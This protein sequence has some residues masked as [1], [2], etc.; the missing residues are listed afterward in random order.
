MNK[1]RVLQ[2]NFIDKTTYANIEDIN[3]SSVEVRL[4]SMTIF[5][6][7]NYYTDTRHSSINL[8]VDSCNPFK[9][10]EHRYLENSNWTCNC[11]ELFTVLSGFS[12][13]EAYVTS[14]ILYETRIPADSIRA[15]YLRIKYFMLSLNYD[16]KQQEVETRLIQAITT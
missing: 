15:T 2:Q 16:A 14:F 7:N 1:Q 13:P 10:A 4:K 6:L 3:S 5:M 9:I 8:R 12:L 11:S